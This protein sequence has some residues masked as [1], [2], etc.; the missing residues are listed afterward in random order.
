MMQTTSVFL[1]RLEMYS[2]TECADALSKPVVGS[3]RKST[4]GSGRCFK[5]RGPFV[6]CFFVKWSSGVCL[7]VDSRGEV[8]GCICPLGCLLSLDACVPFTKPFGSGRVV[9]GGDPH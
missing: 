6:V 7:C 4:S 5:K 9:C 2:T 1:A 8:T 3:S